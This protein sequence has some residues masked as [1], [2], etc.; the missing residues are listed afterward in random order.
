MSKI[1][2]TKNEFNLIL[3]KESHPVYIAEDDYEIVE[4]Q[5]GCDL[6]RRYNII[7]DETKEVHIMDVVYNSSYGDFQDEPQDGDFYIDPD[8]E[9]I[10]DSLGELL[11]EKEPEPE[12]EPELTP[13]DIMFN[14]YNDMKDK[15]VLKETDLNGLLALLSEKEIEDIYGTIYELTVTKKDSATWADV[16]A[17]QHEIIYPTAIKYSLNADYLWRHT[18]HDAINYKEKAK[19]S[20]KA[21]FLKHYLLNK[22]RANYGGLM[23]Q[24]DGR[25]VFIKNKELE[26]IR[27]LPL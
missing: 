10:Y 25:E 26:M 14:T 27:S 16:T 5:S 24:I 17:F 22:E 8:K 9:D 21:S 18:W 19:Y 3:K 11:S 15:G 7:N 23:V 12:P 2:L 4:E 1:A 6:L 20:R 13:L